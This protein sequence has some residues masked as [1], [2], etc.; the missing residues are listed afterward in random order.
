MQ[1]SERKIYT[2][3]EQ[4]NGGTMTKRIKS[5]LPLVMIDC[6]LVD[7]PKYIRLHALEYPIMPSLAR[8]HFLEYSN[9]CELI[10]YTSLYS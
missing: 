5:A 10:A 9:A 7:K 1:K 2:E 4:R 3:M 8:P 6:W